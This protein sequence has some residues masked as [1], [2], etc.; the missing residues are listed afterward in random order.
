MASN[1]PSVIV[2]P[3]T[4]LDP[5]ADHRFKGLFVACAN[6]QGTNCYL[7]HDKVFR[8]SALPPEMQGI[9]RLGAIELPE[10]AYYE[11]LDRIGDMCESVGLEHNLRST[12]PDAAKEQAKEDFER[13]K[14]KE[15]LAKYGIPPEGDSDPNAK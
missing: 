4:T 6:M 12:L 1:L 8:N 15:Y 10:S 13:A 3:F 9:D 14:L 11:D 5:D 2:I 7:C